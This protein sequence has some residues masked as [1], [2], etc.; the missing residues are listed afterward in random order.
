MGIP[1]PHYLL[2]LLTWQEWLEWEAR[3][4]A[5]PWGEDR[6]D[7]RN[8]VLLHGILAPWLEGPL[9]NFSWPYFEPDVETD[10]GAALEAIA[11]HKAKYGL[12]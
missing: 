2:R 8:V 10:G 9:P 4:D 3:Y 1:H 7:L 6:T 5:N 12:P 11:S